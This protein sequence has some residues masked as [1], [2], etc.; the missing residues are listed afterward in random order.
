MKTRDMM[1]IDGAK[2]KEDIQRFCKRNAIKAEPAA[3]LRGA[4]S[5]YK[6]LEN[7][8]R[9]FRVRFPDEELCS[10]GFIAIRESAFRQVCETFMLT[11]D[12]YI[13][14]QKNKKDAET[15]TLT[16][17]APTQD[18]TESCGESTEAKADGVAQAEDASPE[19]RDILGNILLTMQEQTA[20][21]KKLVEAW[22]K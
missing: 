4:S 13:V 7:G 17:T 12:K 3:R 1:I 15:L 5:A 11:P 21:M 16:A 20:I 9:A 19:L 18:S 6:A 14:A 2:V 10:M 22:D 8:K